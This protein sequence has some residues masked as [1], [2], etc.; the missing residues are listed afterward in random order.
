MSRFDEVITA[1]YLKNFKRLETVDSSDLNLVDEDGRTPLMHA[2]LAEN[3]DN[4]IVNML[5]ER[6]AEVNAQ[7]KGRCWTTLHFAA[8]AERDDIVTVLLENGAT[9]DP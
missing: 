8:Q 6:G 7:D 4:A 2:V 1:I 3:A 9:V 5:I